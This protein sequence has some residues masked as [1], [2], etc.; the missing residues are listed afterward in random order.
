[1]S[2]K[3]TLGQIVIAATVMVGSIVV[4]VIIEAF[5]EEWS[6]PRLATVAIVSF[7][8][9]YL[10]QVFGGRERSA[11]KKPSWIRRL[12]SKKAREDAMVAELLEMWDKHG[13][14]NY[15]PGSVRQKAQWVEEGDDG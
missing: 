10:V 11:P 13:K 2:W 7:V 6:T 12:F 4:A 14:A 8:I 3:P 1:M 5:V 15:S 9:A